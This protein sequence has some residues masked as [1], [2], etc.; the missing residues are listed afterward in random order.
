MIEMTAVSLQLAGMFLWFS[1]DDLTLTC[2]IRS[3]DGSSSFLAFWNGASWST[4]GSTLG[5]S[6]ISQ[7]TLVPLL[8][9]HS[10]NSIVQQD[11][12]LLV[13]GALEDSAFGSAS[14]AL[15]DGENFIPYIMASSANGQAG[16]I[17]QLFHSASTFSFNQR[18]QYFPFLYLNNY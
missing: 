14:S 8:D 5:P 7:L 6:N 11:R 16:S 9:T 2:S 1:A 12:M 15:F 4:V 18:R 13:S 3:S 17:S 10:A